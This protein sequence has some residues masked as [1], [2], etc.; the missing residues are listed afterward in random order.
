[1]R[2]WK[3]LQEMNSFRGYTAI[4]NSRRAKISDSKQENALTLEGSIPINSRL[5]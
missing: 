3:A 2:G 1:L 5:I 4:P